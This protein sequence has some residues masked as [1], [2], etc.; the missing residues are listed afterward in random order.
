MRWSE[1]IATLCSASIN[2]EVNALMRIGSLITST[3]TARKA[4]SSAAG[5]A[6]LTSTP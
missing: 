5:S 6:P 3:V 4:S 2:E 1:F